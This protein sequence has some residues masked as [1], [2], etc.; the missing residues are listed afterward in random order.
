MQLIAGAFIISTAFACVIFNMAFVFFRVNREYGASLAL[1]FT[2]S[3][4]VLLGFDIVYLMEP[5][6]FPFL[7]L[8]LLIIVYLITGGPGKWLRKKISQAKAS[9]TDVSEAAFRRDAA[10][11]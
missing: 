4:L 9:L 6:R 2:T 1:A 7:S 5:G 8:T 11:I 10:A 3:Y